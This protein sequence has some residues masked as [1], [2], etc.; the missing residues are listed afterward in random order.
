MSFSPI[1]WIPTKKIKKG[2]K[3][4]V[5]SIPDCTITHYQ[6]IHLVPISD[7]VEEQE[8]VKVISKEAN[9]NTEHYN[10]SIKVDEFAHELANISLPS[11]MKDLYIKFSSPIGPASRK[12]SLTLI[13]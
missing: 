13:L 7:M 11:Y 12:R 9:T 8:P 4:E 10:D 3:D 6:S 1:I 5:L 2:G